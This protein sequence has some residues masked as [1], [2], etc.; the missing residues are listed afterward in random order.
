MAR[1]YFKD[2]SPV[3]RRIGWK[4]PN[5]Q[6]SPWMEVIGVAGD[7]KADGLD[8]ASQHTIYQADTQGFAP[9]TFLVRA[10]GNAEHLAPQVVETIRQLDPQRPIDHI[11]T[12]EEI[13]EESIAPQR[14]NAILIGLFA[15]LALSI[16]TVGVA[17]VLSFSVSQRTNE[18][19]IRL[20]LGAK[21]TAILGMIL[22]E[23]ALMTVIG[24]A[25]GGIASIPL[26]RA[27]SGLLFG[28]QPADPATIVIASLVLAFVALAAAF[29]PARRATRVDPMIALRSE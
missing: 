13:R 20:A 14:L 18:L 28:V 21:R 9:S 15:V 3:G 12:L 22:G 2:Q 8:Q 6:W 24:L 27:L 25:I 17:G 16:A 26:T 19:G 4:M 1:F 7:T 10:D 29:I 5:G 11:Q 23:G